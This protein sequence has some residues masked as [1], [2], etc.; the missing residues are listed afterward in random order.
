[1]LLPSLCANMP[2]YRAHKEQFEIIIALLLVKIYRVEL[3][4]SE[5]KKACRILVY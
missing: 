1:M 5:G 3:Y 2:S 4:R